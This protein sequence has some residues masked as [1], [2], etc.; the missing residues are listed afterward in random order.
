MVGLE[1]AFRDSVF[2]V[3]SVLTTTGF[4]TADFT[5]WGPFMMMLFFVLM[6]VGANAGS[7]SGDMKLI[8]ILVVCKNCYYE[9]KRQIHPKAIIPVRFNNKAVSQEVV[10]RIMAFFLIF[11]LTGYLLV[12]HRPS[13]RC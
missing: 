5:T 11:I 4:G 7:T 10:D 8:R 13:G 2:Q 3:L 6:F 1:Q 9:L 12:V